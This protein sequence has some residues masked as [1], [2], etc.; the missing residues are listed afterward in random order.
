MTKKK[1][2]KEEQIRQP[3][4][5]VIL[6]PWLPLDHPFR[7]IVENALGAVGVCE[8]P[9]GSN[10]A[11][12][13]DEWNRRAKVP[14]GSFY[15][16]SGTAAWWQDAGFDVP[17]YPAGCDEWRTW[18][19]ETG[20]WSDKPVEGAVVV[21]GTSADANHQGV[22]VRLSPILMDVEANTSIGGF[23][24]NGVATALK[25]VDKDRVLGYVHPLPIGK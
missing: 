15:C 16:A 14:V 25:V 2:Q 8:M 5:P 1:T 24:R 22:V 6:A 17:N 3:I 12:E 11:P 23:S 21:Y 4:P 13:I 20:R 7:L 9:P 10:R 19:N 18:A